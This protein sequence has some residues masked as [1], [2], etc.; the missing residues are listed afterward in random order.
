MPFNNGPK[1]ATQGLAFLLDAADAFSYPG[2][3]TTWTDIIGGV[4]GSISGSVSYTSNFYGGFNF[5][6]PTASV[7]FDGTNIA[8]YGTSSFTVELAFRPDQINGIHY[9]VS[10]NSGSFP[11]WGVYLS[12]SGGQGRL[13]SEY[14]ISST[15]SC[16]FSSSTVFTTGSNYQID[17][18]FYPALS[19]SS[20][21]I[22]G[23]T[24][25]GGFGNG[26]GSLTSTGSLFFGNIA[27]SS[28]QTFSGSLFATKIYSSLF[29]SQPSINYNA[30]ASRLGKPNITISVPVFQLLV[31]GAGGSSQGGPAGGGGA[32]GLIYNSNFTPSPGITVVT[33]G[34]SSA[35]QNGQNS[36]FGTEVAI[37]GGRGI[38]ANNGGSGGSGGGGGG[39]NIRTGGA[40]TAGQGFAGGNNINPGSPSNPAAYNG[41]AAGGGAGGAGSNSLGEYIGSPG[42]VGLYID[43]FSTIGGSPAGWF[44]GGGGGGDI[45][46]YR[47]ATGS[48]RGGLGGGGTGSLGQVEFTGPTIEAT[49]GIPNTG[50]GGG[51][52][53]AGR[54]G[55]LGGTGIVAIRYNGAPIATGG[56]ITQSAGYTYHV[57]RTTGS[58]TFVLF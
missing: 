41:S 14:R 15:I 28:S 58:S 25:G 46:S 34:S 2:S 55:A 48:F 17:A 5:T 24:I 29:L 6:G 16:S 4:T 31:V 38:S 57:F 30:I 23:V 22:D 42:G 53:G 52:T 44:A 40:G 43:T 20:F 10:K 54:A 45:Y 3:G 36:S 35:G 8:N 18:V 9:L 26:G 37:G 27:P 13:F 47:S 32:G 49:A 7:R 39:Y 33:V 12:G 51:G 19:A 11:S 21:Y 56:E 50:G 1:L